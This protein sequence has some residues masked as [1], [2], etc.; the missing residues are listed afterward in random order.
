MNVPPRTADSLQLPRDIA[1]QLTNS[2]GLLA[3]VATEYLDDTRVVVDCSGEGTKHHYDFVERCWLPAFAVPRADSSRGQRAKCVIL[4][5]ERRSTAVL[6]SYRRVQEKQ[7]LGAA[8]VTGLQASCSSRL[9]A[10]RNRRSIGRLLKRNR[11][12]NA[13]QRRNTVCH[14][15]SIRYLADGHCQGNCHCAACPEVQLN[16]FE[17]LVLAA[18]LLRRRVSCLGVRTYLCGS[19]EA[20]FITPP[21][22]SSKSSTSANSRTGSWQQSN[23]RPKNGPENRSEGQETDNATI[24]M[25]RSFIRIIHCTIFVAINSPIAL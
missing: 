11:H 9:V 3:H 13:S 16:V 18:W 25:K 8:A 21:I 2:A 6:L 17:R 22:C 14:G 12:V 5:L 7:R 10:M 15:A 1:R 23:H 24:N 4:L 20:I 19:C